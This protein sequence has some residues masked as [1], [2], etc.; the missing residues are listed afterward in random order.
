MK[1]VMGE[2]SEADVVS[3]IEVAVKKCKKGELVRLSVK[4]RYGYKSQGHACYNIPPDAD[5]SYD[6]EIIDF[7]RVIICQFFHFSILC[8]IANSFDE[9]IL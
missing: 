8:C 1:F 7:V 3:G 2:G 4:S 9:P 5:L 6:V